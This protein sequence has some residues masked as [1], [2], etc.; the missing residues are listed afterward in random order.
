M[1]VSHPWRLRTELFGFSWRCN[2]S[3]SHTGQP[4]IIHPL[5]NGTI[6][7]SGDCWHRQTCRGD[8]NPLLR[9]RSCSRRPQ[10]WR[11]FIV[12]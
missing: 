9:L 10:L 6:S 2:R 11:K 3:K 7:E 4:R 1:Y 12:R 8:R 5:S